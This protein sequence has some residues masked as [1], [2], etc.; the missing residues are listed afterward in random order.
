MI[1]MKMNIIMSL[2][3]L[4]TKIALFYTKNCGIRYHK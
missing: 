4:K 2:P 1:I 3:P